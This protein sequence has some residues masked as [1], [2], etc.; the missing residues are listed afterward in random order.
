MMDSPNFSL[1]GFKEFS[2]LESHITYSADRTPKSSL[3]IYP[4][5]KSSC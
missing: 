1:S 2:G 3:Y 5:L 4:R